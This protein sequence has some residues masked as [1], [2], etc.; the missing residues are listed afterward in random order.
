M[1]HETL[2]SALSPLPRRAVARR[3]ARIRACLRHPRL[4]AALAQGADPWSTG[5]LAARAAQL[6]SLAYRR[7]LSAGLIALVELA[8]RRQ[9][10]SPYVSVRQQVVLEER[11]S[12]LALAERLG[13]LEPVEVA[14]AAQLSQLLSDPSS[15]AFV[16][17]SDPHELADLT[18]RCL[19]RVGGGA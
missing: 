13:R 17:G 18:S 14:V 12:L 15:P 16:G 5:E 7:K 9:P 4:D 11:D 2:P 6:S 3:L 19:D 1:S 10:L 8:E